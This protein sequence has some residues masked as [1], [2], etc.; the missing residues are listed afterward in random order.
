[1]RV[2]LLLAASTCY[3]R[4]HF[5]S[6]GSSRLDLHCNNG[7]WEKFVQIFRPWVAM[8][9]LLA[10]GW[11]SGGIDSIKFLNGE[12]GDFEPWTI[13][14][15]KTTQQGSLVATSVWYSCPTSFIHRRG[16][17][18]K[19]DLWTEELVQEFA[20]G[21]VHRCSRQWG[22]GARNP[23][24]GCLVSRTSKTRE[25]AARYSSNGG[26]AAPLYL[27]SDGTRNEYVEPQS[28]SSEITRFGSPGAIDRVP[29]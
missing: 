1:M 8:C 12:I 27:W 21:E 28:S 23:Q 13:G 16:I 9:L 19:Y 14:C 20:N 15:E 24:W 11:V 18:Q 25:G 5:Y 2:P 26:H 17:R 29:Y 4:A 6:E 3:P 22:F 7:L 10:S